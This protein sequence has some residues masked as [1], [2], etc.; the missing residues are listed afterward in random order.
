MLRTS[1][2]DDDEVAQS[3]ATLTRHLDEFVEHEAK[4]RNST[5]AVVLMKTLID[6]HSHGRIPDWFALLRRFDGIAR[7]DPDFAGLVARAPASADGEP[8]GF[9]FVTHAVRLPGLAALERLFDELE[10]LSRKSGPY[11]SRLCTSRH[12]RCR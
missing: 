1:I 9:L 3:A 10:G 11:G 12:R 8:M 7:D 6:V 5:I 4:A 2:G